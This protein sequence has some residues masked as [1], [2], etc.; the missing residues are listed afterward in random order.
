MIIEIY[1]NR[2]NYV[3]NFSES[4]SHAKLVLTV[5][6]F[7]LYSISFFVK[8]TKC[9]YNEA[10]FLR[11][12]GSE[13]IDT[14][15]I[16]SMYNQVYYIESLLFAAVSI[17]ILNFLRLNDYIRLFFSSI[18][19]SLFLFLKYSIFF[20]VILIGYACI[21][22]ILWGPYI[23]DFATFGGSF[24]QVLLFTMGMYYYIIFRLFQRTTIIV[25]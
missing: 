13:Y 7:V 12:D 3:K 24:I 18:E 5:A 4:I 11:L 23:T 6:I 21:A 8:L 20:I 25:L 10:D 2:R 14:Y 22:H 1:E 19:S 15:S 16:A 9:Y 17:K